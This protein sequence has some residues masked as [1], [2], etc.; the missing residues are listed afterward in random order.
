MKCL[1][2][3]GRDCPLVTEDEPQHGFQRIVKSGQC[4]ARALNRTADSLEDLA[5]EVEKLRRFK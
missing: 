3:K 5:E 1:Y 4:L 2:D